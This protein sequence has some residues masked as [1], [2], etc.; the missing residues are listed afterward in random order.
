M[1]IEDFENLSSMDENIFQLLAPILEAE[2]FLLEQ[3]HPIFNP[4]KDDGTL[5]K[6]RRSSRYFSMASPH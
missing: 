4:R 3:V 1:Q 2:P 6:K 5:V